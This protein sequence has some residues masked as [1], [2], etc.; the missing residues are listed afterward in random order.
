M[1]LA[2][3]EPLFQVSPWIAGAFLA[4]R[5]VAVAIH[6]AERIILVS[7]IVKRARPED[8]P[9]VMKEVAPILPSRAGQ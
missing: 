8:L 9:K 1:R 3:L 4:V 2:E 6:A 5:I 7:M